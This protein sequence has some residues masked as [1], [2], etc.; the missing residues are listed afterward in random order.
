MQVD[1]NAELFVPG[2]IKTFTGHYFDVLN[3]DP[4]LIDIRDIAHSLAQHPR[5]GGHLP[6]FYSVGAHSLHVSYMLGNGGYGRAIELMGLLH[7][8][9]EAYIADMP[10]PIKSSLPDYKRMERNLQEAIYERFN[11]FCYKQHHDLLKE[12]D[13]QALKVE[14]NVLMQGRE[15]CNDVHLPGLRLLNMGNVE[16]MF[17]HQFRKL[18]F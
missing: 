2:K 8:A 12:A 14:W 6:K 18:E 4:A 13:V 11:I 16:M 17:L 1:Y 15:Q 5:Y 9:S 10:S 3:P 7:D